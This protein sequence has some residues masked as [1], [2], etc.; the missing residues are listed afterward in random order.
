MKYRNCKKLEGRLNRLLVQAPVL[1]SSGAVNTDCVRI[2]GILTVD[3]ND[4]LAE[5]CMQYTR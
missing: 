4:A 3:D 2:K 5:L 1:L